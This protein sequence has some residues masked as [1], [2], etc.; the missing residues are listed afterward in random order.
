MRK[1]WHITICLILNDSYPLLHFHLKLL[2]QVITEFVLLFY[3]IGQ[4]PQIEE[5]VGELD[6]IS[7]LII[8]ELRGVEWVHSLFLFPLVL[9]KT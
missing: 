4:E 3:K 8:N 1:S 9:G 7:L 5:Q 2:I 6:S